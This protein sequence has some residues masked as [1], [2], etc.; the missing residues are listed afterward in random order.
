M[1]QYFNE[2]E[3][4][5]LK[6]PSLDLGGKES[7]EL[8]ELLKTAKEQKNE[9]PESLNSQHL[10]NKLVSFLENTFHGDPALIEK[11]WM[12]QK[13]PP[14]EGNLFILDDDVIKYI[15]SIMDRYEAKWGKVGKSQSYHR[16]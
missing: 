1:K 10:A 11:Y 9:D 16:E 8:V 14:K 15:E 7:K 13:Q 3:L 12:L 4:D 2:R 5:I 6:S